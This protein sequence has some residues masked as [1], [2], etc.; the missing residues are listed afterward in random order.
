MYVNTLGAMTAGFIRGVGNYLFHKLAQK[1]WGQF[2]RCGVLSYNL[3]KAL[4]IDSLGF[5][6]IYNSLHLLCR[7]LQRFLLFLVSSGLNTFRLVVAYSCVND[8]F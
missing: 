4:D 8:V 7:L 6:F 1:G 2:C 5:N 3:Q